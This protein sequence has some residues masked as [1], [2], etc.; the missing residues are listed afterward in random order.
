MTTEPCGDTPTLVFTIV[1]WVQPGATEVLVEQD[2]AV[3]SV[4]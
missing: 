1:P 4:S 2:Q 3:L